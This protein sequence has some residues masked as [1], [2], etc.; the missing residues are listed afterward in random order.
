MGDIYEA[1]KLADGAPLVERDYAAYQE[2]IRMS[3]PVLAERIAV[4]ALR[5]ASAIRYGLVSSDTPRDGL[6]MPIISNRLDDKR[7]R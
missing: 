1:M 2:A 3:D 7:L 5:T 6:P 4:D